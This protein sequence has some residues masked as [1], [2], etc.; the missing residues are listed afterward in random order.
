MTEWQNHLQK[1][2]I[3]DRT[4]QE[5]LTFLEI[6]TKLYYYIFSFY[7]SDN[8]FNYGKQCGSRKDIDKKLDMIGDGKLVEW[9]CTT[10]FERWVVVLLLEGTY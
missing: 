6:V 1:F 10:C 5:L 9:Y 8:C 2:H 3:E 4:R 7:D